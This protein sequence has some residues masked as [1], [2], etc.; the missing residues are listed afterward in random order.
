MSD[1]IIFLVA[2]AKSALNILGQEEC[3]RGPGYW[4]RDYKSAKQCGSVKYCTEHH[5]KKQIKVIA[6]IKVY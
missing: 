1:C 2:S 5:W 4:C 6:Y 3:T